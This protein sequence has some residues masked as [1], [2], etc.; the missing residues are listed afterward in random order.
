MV[1]DL[2]RLG[3][4]PFHAPAYPS[5]RYRFT[6]REYLNITYRTDPDALRAIVPEPL[7]VDEPLVRFEV[8]RMGDV[9]GLGPYVESGQAIRVRYGDEQ[10]ELLHAMYLDNVPAI[11]SGREISG[12]PKTFG[13]PRLFVEHGVLVG[14]L[15][16]GSVRVAT[17]TM[18]YK[19]QPMDLDQARAEISVPTFMVKVIPG[20]RRVPVIYEL[21]RTQITDLTI[22][23]AWTGPSRL[24]LFQHVLVPMAD[25]PV[26]EIVA[27]SHIIADL[28]LAP[29]EPV[30]DYLAR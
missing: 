2:S 22:T 8:M 7:T 9:T 26:L 17:A 27:A 21:V 15:D 6:D 4:T 23:A 25:L 12:F 29:A 16:Y 19:H 30:C 18:G 14:T 5:G 1:S 10:G 3:T 24:Q 20:Y 28:T 11:T 13:T